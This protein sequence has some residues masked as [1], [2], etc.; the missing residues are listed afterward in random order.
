M[1]DLNGPFVFGTTSVRADFGTA[2]TKVAI[3][4]GVDLVPVEWSAVTG[5]IRRRD[6]MWF[7]VSS[8][9]RRMA[10]SAGGL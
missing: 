2:F 7:P 9:V 6:A 8:F 4:A 10:S 3:R 5:T 1:D